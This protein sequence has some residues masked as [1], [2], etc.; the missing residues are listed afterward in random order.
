MVSLFIF[1]RLYLDLNGYMIFLFVW[2]LDYYSGG[3]KQIKAINISLTG[4]LLQ[5]F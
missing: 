5:T 4:M 1:L 3:A 2:L